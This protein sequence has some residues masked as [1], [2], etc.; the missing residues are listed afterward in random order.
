MDIA[1]AASFVI[2]TKL[3]LRCLKVA[4]T[5]LPSGHTLLP[6]PIKIPQYLCCIIGWTL[7][8]KVDKKLLNHHPFAVDRLIHQPGGGRG[9]NRLRKW[10]DSTI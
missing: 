3:A 4:R 5:L 2:L 1:G 7:Y 8:R 6:S 9:A 10:Y